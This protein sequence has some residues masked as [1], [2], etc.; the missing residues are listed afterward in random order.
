MYTRVTFAYVKWLIPYLNCQGS[1]L[2]IYF[3]GSVHPNTKKIKFS[4]SMPSQW[5]WM[6]F[7]LL[8]AFK[9]HFKKIKNYYF[10]FFFFKNTRSTINDILVTYTILHESRNLRNLEERDQTNKWFCSCIFSNIF[11]VSVNSRLF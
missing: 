11:N 8:Y 6:E 5:K 2:A 3:K 9:A 1:R 4:V 7:N 10:F